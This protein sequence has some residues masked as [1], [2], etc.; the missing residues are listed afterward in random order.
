MAFNIINHSSPEDAE[1]PYS[2]VLEI[3]CQ[4][5]IVI[6]GQV[7]EDENDNTL[8][9]NIT[10]QAEYALKNCETQ[11]AKANCTLENVFKVNVYI[12]NIEDWATFNITYGAFFKGKT[13]PVRA[14]VQTGLLSDFL[15]EIEMWAAK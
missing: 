12:R 6:S 15:V 8:G 7:A 5:L 1:L 10:E 2:T 9:S 14:T 13:K 4:K 11:L 3:E